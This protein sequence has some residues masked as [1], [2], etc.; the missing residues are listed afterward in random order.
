MKCPFKGRAV[1]PLFQKII[2]GRTEKRLQPALAFIGSQCAEPLQGL[3]SQRVKEGSCPLLLKLIS[4]HWHV[5]CAKNGWRLAQSQT[6]SFGLA[7]PH[8]TAVVIELDNEMLNLARVP[9]RD[10]S[11]VEESTRLSTF[12]F[13][14]GDDIKTLLLLCQL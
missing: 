8:F 10:T 12:E 14:Q 3:T 4:Q 5:L 1:I 7:W 2:I 9:A 11:Q 6:M 13:L